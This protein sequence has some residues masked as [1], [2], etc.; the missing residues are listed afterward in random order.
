MSEGSYSGL[1]M[2]Y[3]ALAALAGAVTALSFRGWKEMTKTEIVMTLLVSSFFAVFA[4]PW[5]AQM[6][7][8]AN[9]DIKAMAFA[10]YVGG[11]GS[12]TF[13]PMLFGWIKRKFGNDE[14]V[15][16]K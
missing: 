9:I 12:N 15:L 16:P 3:L 1:G 6:A 14:E 11:S 4:V 5:L 7:F 10:I 13:L 2:M 8:G